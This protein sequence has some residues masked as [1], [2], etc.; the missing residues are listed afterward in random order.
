MTPR[1]FLELAECNSIDKKRQS[2][3][4]LAISPHAESLSKAGMSIQKMELDSND[5]SP[6][7][8]K[9]E[10]P[11]ADDDSKTP[12]EELQTSSPDGEEEPIVQI[13]NRR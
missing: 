5:V 7:L 4:K 12:I 9:E 6:S 10:D 2:G 13:G 11:K 1:T 8:A 3:S